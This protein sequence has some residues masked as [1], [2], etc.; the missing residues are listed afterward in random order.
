VCFFLR[1]VMEDPKFETNKKPPPFWR[2][3]KTHLYAF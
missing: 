3:L 2:G 1:A